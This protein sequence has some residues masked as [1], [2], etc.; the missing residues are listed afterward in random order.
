VIQRGIELLAI[1]LWITTW[2]VGKP[3]PL[4]GGVA[5]VIEELQSLDSWKTVFSNKSPHFQNPPDK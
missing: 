1:S 5:R 2:I 4:Q 3:M